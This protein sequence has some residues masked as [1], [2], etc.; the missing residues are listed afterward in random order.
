MLRRDWLGEMEDDEDIADAEV[1]LRE[2]G[3]IPLTD[4]KRELEIN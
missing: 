3:F 4:V 1:A 2:D